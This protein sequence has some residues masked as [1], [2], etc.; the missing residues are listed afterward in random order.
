MEFLDYYGQNLVLLMIYE[1]ERGSSV[2]QNGRQDIIIDSPLFSVEHE[3]GHVRSLC[4]SHT[5]STPSIQ[6]MFN[7][8]A[9]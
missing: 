6:F 2:I 5:V 4:Q 9:V 8:V 7:F 3:H 1:K